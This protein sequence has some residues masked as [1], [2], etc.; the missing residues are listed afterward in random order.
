MPPTKAGRYEFREELGRGAMGV[1]YKGFDPMIR[2]TVAIKTMRLNEEGTGMEKPEL[3]TRF[4]TEARAAGVLTHSNIV[5]VYDAGEEGGLFYITMEFVEGRSLQALLDQK[6]TF[7]LPRVIKIMEQACLALDFAHSHSIVHR[8]VKPANIMLTAED[9]AKVT[10][11]GT[12]KIMQLGTT[13]TGSII[14]TPSYMSPEQVKGK[15]VDGRSD[16]FSLGVILY[17]MVVGEKPFPGQNVTTVIYKIVN[18][19]PIPPRELDSS[20]H[21]GLSYVISRALAKNPD[22]RYQ[23]CRE[24]AEDL[25]N[26]RELSG[27]AAGPDPFAQTVVMLG[28]PKLPNIPTVVSG[29]PHIPPPPALRT[30]HSEAET[31]PPAS[32]PRP[33]SAGTQAPRTKPPSTQQRAQKSGVLPDLPSDEEV[34][35]PAATNASSGLWLTL[36]LLLVLAGGG[37]FMWSDIRDILGLSGPPKRAVTAPQPALP[38]STAPDSATPPTK[39]A[40]K[41]KP[42][43]VPDKAASGAASP[44]DVAAAKQE[45]E[46]QLAAASLDQKVQ[47]QASGSTLRLTGQLTPRENALLQAGIRRTRIPSGVRLENRVQLARAGLESPAVETSD[48]ESLRPKTSKGMGEV[49]V[50]TDAGAVAILKD[51]KGQVVATDKT[52]CRFEDVPPGRYGVEV[53]RAGFRTERRFVSVRAG[54]ISKMEVSL[55]A[56]ASGI[57]IEGKPDRAEVLVN[58][59]KYGEL[60]PTTIFLA[61]GTYLIS[62]QKTGYE[63]TQQSVE[64]KSEELRRLRFDLPAKAGAATGGGW[65]YLEVRTIPRGADILL[66]DQH[67]GNKSPHRLELRPGRYDLTLYLRGFKQHRRTVLIEEGQTLQINAALEKP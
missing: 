11:F 5:T 38:V 59:R 52:P 50:I 66:N 18:E 39:K 14:G 58:G 43:P 12:A 42:A 45:I 63:G 19:D 34:A 3:I 51:S 10:D 41:E 56:E 54:N 28:P 65:G 16:I 55:K 25:R 17:E 20:V 64:L 23:T 47:V 4:Q 67:S 40:A 31:L 21:P 36:V 7:P 46:Q 9:V 62:V 22:Q 13:Q 26:Y 24:M 60:T 1:V 61:P 37:Y 2:R 33:A 27:A 32:A 30:P 44:P 8:D 35:P 48:P 53:S 57:I 29:A 15:L 49:E 6:Q